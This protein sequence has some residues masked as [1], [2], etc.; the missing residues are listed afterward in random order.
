MPVSTPTSGRKIPPRLWPK[1]MRLRDDGQSSEK[2]A[3]QLKLEH[4]IEITPRSVSRLIV[5]LSAKREELVVTALQ[6]M[7]LDAVP[8]MLDKAERAAKRLNLLVRSET[9]TMKV[10]AGLRGFADALD[11]VAKLGGVAT[12]SSLDVTSG[13]KRIDLRKLSDAELDAEIARLASAEGTPGAAAS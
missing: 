2:I 12:A 13:G 9:D 11:K 10:A 3:A 7:M 5:R 6:Q 4:G 1:V 8:G